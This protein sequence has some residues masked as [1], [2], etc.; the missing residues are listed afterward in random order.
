MVD[1]VSLCLS[2]GSI[3]HRIFCCCCCTAMLQHYW[4]FVYCTVYSIKSLSTIDCTIHKQPIM[5]RHCSPA[6]ATEY[7][8][9]LLRQDAVFGMIME[10][11]ERHRDIQSIIRW[12]EFRF[13]SAQGK[14]TAVF[15][16]QL[17]TTAA[18]EIASMEKLRKPH[19]W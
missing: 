15:M 8:M 18:V 7:P 5:L 16:L 13:C 1:C 19:S 12:Y 11:E 6:T 4:L 3:K 2:S 9:L 14:G 10:H 17:E